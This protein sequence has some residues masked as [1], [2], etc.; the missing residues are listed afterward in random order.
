MSQPIPN[1]AKPPLRLVVAGPPETAQHLQIAKDLLASHYRVQ[2]SLKQSITDGAL[3]AV[4]VELALD[5]SQ[6]QEPPALYKG[7]ATAFCPHG[8]S[9]PIDFLFRVRVAPRT[10]TCRVMTSEATV[11]E[12]AI[13]TLLAPAALPADEYVFDSGQG[14]WLALPADDAE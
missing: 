8:A 13:R 5:L 4:Q 14:K 9:Q 7:L 12:Q 2:S 11:L 1:G 3:T 6:R 10:V